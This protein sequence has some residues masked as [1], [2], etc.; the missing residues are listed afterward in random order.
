[1]ADRKSAQEKGV[2]KYS[3]GTQSQQ[4]QQVNVSFTPLYGTHDAYTSIL[5]YLLTITT[6]YESEGE[7]ASGSFTDKTTILLDCGWDERFEEQI[8]KE[9]H[10]VA[11]DIDAI[12]ISQPDLAH[13][14]ALPYLI[15]K[16]KCR[17][18]VLMTIPVHKMGQMFLYDAFLSVNDMRDVDIITLDQ[19]D[20]A[21][22]QVE[23]DGQCHQLR[24]F[25]EVYLKD[26][27]LV[28]GPSGRVLGGAIWS[29][30]KGAEHI[31]YA[32]DWSHRSELHVA[33]T[34]LAS[35]TE[36]QHPTVLI[37]DAYEA[38]DPLHKERAM[39]QKSNTVSKEQSIS[40]AALYSLRSGGN[41]LFAGDCA[42]RVLELLLRLDESWNPNYP[43]VFLNHVAKNILQFVKTELEWMNEK[44]VRKFVKDNENPFDLKHVQVV[45]SLQALKQIKS[46]KCVV[47]SLPSLDYGFSRTLFTEWCD[48]SKNAVFLLQR[49]EEGTTARTLEEL[50][51]EPDPVAARA[52]SD[53]TGG[54]LGSIG[55]PSGSNSAVSVTSWRKV[56]LSE[57]ELNE[58]R[59]KEQLK[60]QAE[61]R[62]AEAKRTEEAIARE[63]AEHTSAQADTEDVAMQ[64]GDSKQPSEK[65]TTSWRDILK[66]KWAM[67]NSDDPTDGIE[68]TP[69]GNA[70]DPSQ[71]NAGLQQHSRFSTAEQVAAA[72]VTEKEQ[73]SVSTALNPEEDRVMTDTEESLPTKSIVEELELTVNCRVKTIN[74]EGRADAKS[75]NNILE[76]VD[77]RRLVVVHSS[78][79]AGEWLRNTS[80]NFPQCRTVDVPHAKETLDLSTGGMYMEATFGKESLRPLRFATVG[81]HRVT[82]LSA[83]LQEKQS[84]DKSTQYEIVPSGLTDED[85]HHPLLLRDQLIPLTQ[86]RESLR[87]LPEE[88]RMTSEFKHG[89][90]VFEKSN[91]VVRRHPQTG[92]VSIEGVVGDHFNRVRDSLYRHHAIV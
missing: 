56:P 30:S 57:N 80:A 72:L 27:K 15:G 24:Y 46:P 8:V 44:I 61:E 43:L 86:V 81:N 28:A 55:L 92:R 69:W 23:Y 10:Q 53:L 16:L 49:S 17:A 32:V 12:V 39:M 91:I 52:F 1:M 54:L 6:T 51:V 78:P 85:S 21:F 67:F 14:G 19:I 73:S 22:R 36:F 71:F 31:I 59:R 40:N 41:V 35:L 79:E 29:I 83:A 26:I 77:P 25:E 60:Q 9:L 47:T 3:R 89:S 82:Y 48:N 76:K 18:P 45:N 84:P 63:M 4:R 64:N 87:R 7:D 90:L 88:R 62:E 74:F 65:D 50:Y 2:V 13:V 70:L 5:C 37:T 11:G 58:W 34:S 66:F 20:N 68:E 75:I 42:G 33:E 38:L